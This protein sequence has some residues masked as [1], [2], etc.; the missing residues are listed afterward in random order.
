MTCSIT[1]YAFGDQLIYTAALDLYFDQYKG[2]GPGY[3]DKP[4]L[5]SPGECS[6]GEIAA[7]LQQCVCVLQDQREHIFRDNSEN[8]VMQMEKKLFQNFKLFG[9][10]ASRS[11][12]MKQSTEL[13]I[14]R[15]NERV[16]LCRSKAKGRHMMVEKEVS[17]SA[18]TPVLEVARC[19]LELLSDS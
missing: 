19:V 18:K 1:V 7:A 4:I 12:I 17:L 9:I 16:I 10:T 13:L 6:E 14:Q 2:I 8:N 11:Q 3:Y 5:I 15:E